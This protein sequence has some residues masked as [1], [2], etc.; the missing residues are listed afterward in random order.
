MMPEMDGIETLKIIHSQGLNKNTPV[1]MLTGNTGKEYIDLY[2]EVGA[3]GYLEKPVMY[4]NL[5]ATISKV[6]NS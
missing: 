6:C 2:E 1:V 3:A 4:E 5:V